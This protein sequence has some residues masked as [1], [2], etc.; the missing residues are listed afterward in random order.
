MLNGKPVDDRKLAPE[1]TD[2]SKHVLYQAYDVTSLLAAGENIL[3][4]TLGN[5]WYGGKYST[6][7]RFAFGPAPCRLIARLEIDY[8]DGTTDSITTGRGWEI[9]EGA[10]RADSLYDGEVHD[11]RLA[12]PDWAVPGG[13]G[14]GWR[15]AL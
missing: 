13:G 1:F 3:G 5:G 15:E 12:R 11:A 8:A 6:S 14:P 4:F 9:A 7:G 10:I 2:P